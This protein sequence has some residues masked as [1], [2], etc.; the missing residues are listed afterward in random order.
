MFGKKNKIPEA[1]VL[2]EDV[3]VDTMPPDFYAGQDPVVKFKSVTREVDL[4]P[5]KQLPITAS[6]KKALDKATVVGGKEVTHPANLLLNRKFLILGGAGLFIVFVLGAGIYYWWSFKKAEEA[7]RRP[8]PPVIETLDNGQ[9]SLITVPTTTPIEIVE[10]TTTLETLKPIE[11]TALDFPSSLLPDSTD[12]DKDRLTDL[13]EDTFFTDPAVP[14]SDSDSFP[15]GHEMFYLYNP[16]GK[17]PQK[18]IDAGSIREYVN[19][20]FGYKLYYPYNWAV[21][22]VDTGG[23]IVVFSTLT[24]ENIEVRSIDKNTTES[25]A[26]WFGRVAT[27]EKYTDL[28][29]FANRFGVSG[30]QRHDELVYYFPT[31]DYVFTI[32]YH[33]EEITA[34]NY[35]L[36]TTMMAQSL[37][38]DEYS[39]PILPPPGLPAT[40]TAPVVSTTP[41]IPAT[42]T[43]FTN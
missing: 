19:P 24:G 5:Q 37:R 9:A 15:D 4:S 14:D 11:E 33:P 25:F 28:K 23:R 36:I 42:T 32:I 17:E 29:E 10:T 34:I 31:K 27:G 8:T 22:N 12:L 6:E 38:F 20:N 7:R 2:K 18:L 21:G 40:S 1:P 30:W 35:R 39:D 41:A 26:E 13:A 43:D 16:A 3:V